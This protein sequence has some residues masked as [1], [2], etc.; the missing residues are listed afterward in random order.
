MLILLF[1]FFQ[2][3]FYHSLV[4]NDFPSTLLASDGKSEKSDSS[5]ITQVKFFYCHHKLIYV[6]CF[7]WIIKNSFQ[8]RYFPSYSTLKFISFQTELVYATIEIFL[9]YFFLRKWLNFI[10]LV[11]FISVR[12]SGSNLWYLLYVFSLAFN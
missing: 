7:N 5:K 4:Q 9:L 1:L 10:S 8:N 12:L 11:E 3:I 6:I 2:N